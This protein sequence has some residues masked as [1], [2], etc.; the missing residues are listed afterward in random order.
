MSSTVRR[1]LASKKWF[2]YILECS[3]GTLYTGI[4]NDISRRIELH[5]SGKASRYT[6]GRRPVTLIY[7]EP[8]RNK[9]FALKKEYVMKSLTRSEKKDY[10]AKHAK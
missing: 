9:S 1:N 4:T 8:C 10:I 2:L 5:N 3:D 7:Q 6:R